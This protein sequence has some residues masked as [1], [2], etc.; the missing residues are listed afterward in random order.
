VTGA[1][2]LIEFPRVLDRIARLAS[3]EP[4]RD[5]V[6]RRAP[7]PD[8]EIAAEALSTTDE[9]AGFLLHRDGWA[10]PPIRDVSQILR[11]LSVP[12]S[13]LSPEELQALGLMLSSSRRA[14]ASLSQEPDFERLAFLRE[15]MLRAPDIED[16]LDRSLDGSGRVTDAASKPLKTVRSEL[17]SQR[18]GLVKRLEQFAR[19]LPSR[20]QVADASVTVRNGRYCIPIRREGLREVGGVVHDES[21]THQT[22]FVEPPTAI[23]A[24]N[25]LVEL[26]RREAREV[27]AVLRALTDLLRPLRESLTWSV[28]ALIQLDALFAVAR[29]GLLH[30]GT[31]PRLVPTGADYSVI[32]GQHPLLLASGAASVPFDLTLALDETVLLVSG[33]NAGGKTVLLK[34]IGLLSAMAQSGIIPPVGPG[35]VLPWFDGLFAVIGDEQSIEASLSTFSAQLVSLREILEHATPASLVLIDEIGGNTDPAEGAALAAAVLL[36]LADHARL[37]VAT[38]H[39]G[40]LK[41]LAAEESRLVNAS[42]H[43]DTRALKP[44]F[45]LVR[46]RPGRSY[47]LEM[48]ERLGLPSELLDVA[49]S[50]LTQEHRHVEQ[51]LGELEA[52]EEEVRRMAHKSRHRGHDLD[53]RS[54]QLAEAERRVER[55]RLEIVARQNEI[56][57]EA[58]RKTERYLLEARAEVERAVADLHRAFQ[59]EGGDRARRD[60]AVTRARRGVERAL[61]EVRDRSAERSAGAPGADP[62]LEPGETIAPAVGDA[63]ESVSMAVS[64]IVR[65]VRDRE[66]VIEAGGLRITLPLVDLVPTSH[67]A[68][69]RSAAGGPG[70]G[71][72]AQPKLPDL[73]PSTEVSL[74]GLRVDEVDAVLL[75][76][77]DAA[78]FGDLPSL[79]IIHG[80]GTG[81]LRAYVRQVLADEGRVRRIRDG[82]FDEGGTGVTVVEFR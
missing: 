72:A 76:A 54:E 37:T 56:E 82:A 39:L 79:R 64:G 41:E 52:G 46:D 8:A 59:E 18:A 1:L 19:R 71:V 57:K 35:T 20:I 9:M 25:R 70:V 53:R 63:V 21:A 24:M 26:D 23:E 5:L 28:D 36:H 27:L 14:R 13:V 17:K 77:L 68:V 80:K 6:R 74:R 66:A 69:R 12:D 42:L 55:A 34:A 60:E 67:K 22:V 49:R 10:P 43:F 45:E 16:R 50:R 31:R 11:L 75:P 32:G 81:A 29:Y 65:E 47:A 33:P 48:A 15:A 4:G 61:A 58:G 62:D 78:V 3:S 2:A 73:V 44:T 51:L 7:L 40:E 30:G 38:T